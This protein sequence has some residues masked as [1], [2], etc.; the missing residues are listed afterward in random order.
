MLA[1]AAHFCAIPLLAAVLILGQADLAAAAG[2]PQIVSTWVTEVTATSAK[3]RAE[4]N[5]NGL[6]TTYR[7]EYLSEAAYQANL[8]AIPPRD[9][10]SGAAK[11][12][13]G[14]AA[15]LGNGST[16]LAVVQNV[17]GLSPVTTYRYRAVATNSAATTTGPDRFLGTEEPTNVFRLLDNRGWEM[18]S[19]V[20]K[21]GGAIQ[22][23]ETL[24]GGGVFQAAAN[25]ESLSYSSADS[26]GAAPAGAPA[27]SQY[28]A[29]RG[30]G[31][32][33]SQNIT[34]PLL[35]GSFGDDPDG[36]PYQLFSPDLARGLLANGQRCRGSSGECPVANPPL[37]GTGAPAGY[38]NYYLRS[39]GGGF[40]S[41]LTTTEVGETPLGP[42]QFELD[43]AA[44]SPDLA[45]VVLS[46]CAALTPDA[47]E[48]AAPG[49]CAPSAQNL[50]EWSG[51]GLALINLLPGDAQGTPGALVA[52]QG[53]AV[54]STGERVYFTA[55]EDGAL[56]LREAG[57]P[58]K[59]VPETSGG[60]AVFQTASSDGRFAFFTKGAHLYRY[61]A[62]A[63]TASDLT[64][65]G[66]VKGVLGAAA[67]GSR[68][69]YLSAAGL[70][71]WASG[72]TTAVAATADASN[73]P[74]TTGSAR[75]SADGTHLAFVSGA[76][77]TGY[78]NDGFSEVFLY[79]PPRGGGVAELVC[80]S[81]NPTG[82]RPSGASS[83]PGAFA[84]GTGP[85][86]T[87]VYK[88][89]SLSDDGSRVFFDS[90][91]AL[92]IQDTNKRPDVYEW[93]APGAG[94]CRRETGC[95]GLISSGRS[96]T[97][98][99][100]IDA[101]ADGSDAFFLTERSL[102]SADP[103]SF[104]LYDARVNG[105]FAAAPVPIPCIGDA[106]QFLPSAPEDPTP[107]TLVPNAGNPPLRV[108]KTQKKKHHKKNK[109]RHHKRR[110][111]K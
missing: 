99:S 50:Y 34:T 92:A 46:S 78:E 110:G 90:S 62:D 66:S 76:E 106:C 12:P 15:A 35:S 30:G 108:V 51:A 52:A 79:G 58:T 6:S 65:G 45:H 8:D 18:V 40:D 104:D 49:G 1:R 43:F 73:Y 53:G 37:P 109:K 26:F 23:P 102:V 69:Y 59:P 64:P 96:P 71:L 111:G 60:G 77:L 68:V 67:D 93:E 13:P 55:L 22:A 5:A 33:S 87:N 91:D 19:P 2:P 21:N 28:L 95:V 103:G 54:S 89:R 11:A 84:N 88:P 17:G 4:I 9:G 42:E 38:R 14:G 82:E 83:I 7:F 74:P 25:G 24:F 81:C 63:G 10:F 56:Y 48:I 70:F 36:V 47:T 31:G 39:N 41:L 105:G 61:D 16:E 44:A 57:G 27:A 32:W 80:V 107:G 75:V 72:T 85:A 20:D 98:S 94:D 86:A 100:F 29:A 101:S 3:L 97:A